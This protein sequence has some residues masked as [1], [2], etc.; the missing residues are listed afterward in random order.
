MSARRLVVLCCDG[1]N[2]PDPPRSDWDVF[3][4]KRCQATF[5]DPAGIQEA[6]QIRAA[7][8]AAGWRYRRGLDLDRCPEHADQP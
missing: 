5:S 1:M 7:A 2:L 6:T 4:A 3:S 8:R